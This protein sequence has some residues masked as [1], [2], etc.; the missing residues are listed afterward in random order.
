M[1][2]ANST[3]GCSHPIQTFA[4]LSRWVN[5][6]DSNARSKVADSLAIYSNALL[7]LF[8]SQINYENY[9]NDNFKKEFVDSCKTG[10][11]TQWYSDSVPLIKRLFSIINDYGR[12][13]DSGSKMRVDAQE[14]FQ[15]P[16]SALYLNA[17]NSSQ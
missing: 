17:P 1:R 14:A 8:V 13:F 2:K 15:F 11:E 5:N 9:Q 12:Q 10:E 16:N 7:S 4:R 6:K 3:E